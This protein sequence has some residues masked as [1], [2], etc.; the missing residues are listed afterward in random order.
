MPPVRERAFVLSAIP[1]H[2]KD[3]IV[4]FLGESSGKKRAVARGA[5]RL[6]SATSGSLEPMTEVEIVHVE[7]EGR[8]LGRI[9]AVT[10]LRSSFPLAARLETALLLSAMA[11]ALTTFVADSDPSE[12]LYRLATHAVDAL[13]EDRP[14]RAVAAYFDVWILKLT[15]VLPETTECAR[16]GEPLEGPPRNFDENAPGFVCARCVRPGARRLS[17]E[18]G[19]VLSEILVRPIP[20]LSAPPRALAEIDFV[21]ARLRRHF[22]GH[23]LKSQRVLEEVWPR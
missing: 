22:L 14:A 6:Q 5:R 13:F 23:E 15:G 21:A 1:L 4:T 8:D 3:R 10:R 9:D 17:P 2:E 7:R 16:C 12:K 19:S 18:F 20:R 11:E